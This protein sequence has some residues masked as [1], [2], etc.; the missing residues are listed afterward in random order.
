MPH[1]RC[2]GLIK[3][4]STYAQP[5]A[6]ACLKIDLIDRYHVLDPTCLEPASLCY[7][8][9]YAIQ[10]VQEGELQDATFCSIYQFRIF[11]LE[12]CAY[13]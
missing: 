4:R 12:T 7:G 13:T 2:L 8:L 1:D 11:F 5:S 10:K 9:W 6:R 3:T